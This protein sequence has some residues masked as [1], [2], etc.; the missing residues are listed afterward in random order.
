M[1]AKKAKKTS[2]KE[3]RIKISRSAAIKSLPKKTPKAAKTPKMKAAKT[4]KKEVKFKE[5]RPLSKKQKERLKKEVL[6]KAEE[7]KKVC[8]K[9]YK[10]LIKTV[11][12]CGSYLRDEHTKDSDLDIFVI[13]DDTKMRI[14]EEFKNDLTTKFYELVKKLDKRLHPQPP[15]TVTEFWDMVRISHPLLMSVLRDGWA[16][17][18]QGFFIP[19]KK[20][21]ERGK[22]PASLEAVELLINSAPQKIER[23]KSVRLYQVSEDCYYAMLNSTQAI[24][25]YLGKHPPAPKNTPAMVKEYLVEAKLLKQEYCDLLDEVI[26]LRKAIEYKKVKELSGAEVD[27]WIKKAED[28]SKQME[29]IYRTIQNQKKRVIIDKNYEVL[30]KSTI[31]TLKKLDKLPPDPKDLPEAIKKELI[32]KNYLPKS[33]LETFDKVVGMKKAAEKEIGKIPERDVEQTRTYVKKFVDLL[34]R[35]I[36]DLDAKEKAY[37][38]QK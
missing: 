11:F 37:Q 9:E 26:K 13:L 12:I 22:I 31:F 33:Y 30:L 3:E 24:L 21:L 34:D 10:D 2:K 16:L 29:K 20:L 4:K 32:A 36:R 8:L 15:W 28:Y 18:D 38:V 1:A 6:T 7:F 27:E 23:A 17:Y 5:S 19:M 14:T 25:M 35:I